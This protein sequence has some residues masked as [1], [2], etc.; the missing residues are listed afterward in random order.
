MSST[1][2]FKPKP[3]IWVV[4]WW[5][6]CDGKRYAT[7]FDTCTTR[8]AAEHARGRIVADGVKYGNQGAQVRFVSPVLRY[9]FD[10]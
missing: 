4:Y 1:D 10:A 6:I 3:V 9:R 7:Q 2:A 5:W 8:S